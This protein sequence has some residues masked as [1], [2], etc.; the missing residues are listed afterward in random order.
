MKLEEKER[1]RQTIQDL[2]FRE[3]KDYNGKMVLKNNIPIKR[4]MDFQE[5]DSLVT[6]LKLPKSKQPTRTK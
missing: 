2:G 6:R 1:L 4:S 3:E 5:V